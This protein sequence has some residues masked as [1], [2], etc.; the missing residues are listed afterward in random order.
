VASGFAD[1]PARARRGSNPQ[2]LPGGNAVFEGFPSEMSG[3]D[4][5]RAAALTR[6]AS[7]TE[8]MIQQQGDE[9]S[10]DAMARQARDVLLLASL[11]TG[12]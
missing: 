3:D 10:V 1:R 8:D 9:I 2:V 12:A 6:R 4:R 7:L 5:T 11:T